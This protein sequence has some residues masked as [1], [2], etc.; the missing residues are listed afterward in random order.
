[1][2]GGGGFFFI[3]FTIGLQRGRDSMVID[4]ERWLLLLLTAGEGFYGHR[5]GK[6][7]FASA[8]SGVVGTMTIVPT[9]PL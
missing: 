1:M 8:Y 6:M 2:Q 5:K 4:R 9:P 7:A 3:G